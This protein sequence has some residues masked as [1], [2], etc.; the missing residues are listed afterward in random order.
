L[1]YIPSRNIR[2]DVRERTSRKIKN[3]HVSYFSLKVSTKQLYRIAI[4]VNKS[5]TA[6]QAMKALVTLL[7]SLNLAIESKTRLFPK[8][9]A[10]IKH[11]FKI[12]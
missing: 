1:S 11:I 9:I 3:M 10:T 5:A 2:D 12:V 7:K 6:R 8:R 4:P